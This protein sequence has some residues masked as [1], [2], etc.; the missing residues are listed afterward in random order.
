[1]K[2]KPESESSLSLKLGGL[3]PISPPDLGGEANGVGGV[4]ISLSMVVEPIGGQTTESVTHDQCDARP[5]VTFPA[6]KH[7]RSLTT[8][9]KLY[10]WMNRGT[11]G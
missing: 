2:L 6:A 7:H 4:L 9:T 11:C 8:G 5:T 3:R 1:M 10:C